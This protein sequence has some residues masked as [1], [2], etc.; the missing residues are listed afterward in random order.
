MKR[1][2]KRSNIDLKDVEEAFEEGLKN[3]DIKFDIHGIDDT[4][5]FIHFEYRPLTQLP[6]GPH[7]PPSVQDA[8]NV[9][10]ISAFVEKGLSQH[11]DVHFTVRGN[12]KTKNE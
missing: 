4:D 8:Y 6:Y 7:I 1:S 10:C 12:E 2:D 11:I 9:Y 3:T 5:F